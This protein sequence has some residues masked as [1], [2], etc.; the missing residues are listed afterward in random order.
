MAALPLGPHP[1]RF[2]AD[3]PESVVQDAAR[4]AVVQKGQPFA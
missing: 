2:W 3:D 1:V 4:R